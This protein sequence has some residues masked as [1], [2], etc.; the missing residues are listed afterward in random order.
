MELKNGLT[1]GVRRNTKGQEQF[2]ELLW[3]RETQGNKTIEHKPKSGEHWRIFHQSYE[4][5]QSEQ[6]KGLPL[7]SKHKIDTQA[8]VEVK[9]NK[10]IAVKAGEE[11]G[12]MGEYNQTGESGEKLLHLEVFT[13]DN[14]EQFKAKAEAA[15]KQDRE[16]KGIKANFLYVARGSQLYSIANDEAVALE[17][18]KVEI[19]VPLADVAKKT[20]KKKTDKTGKDYYNVQ[21]YLYSLP[22]KNKDGGIYVDSSHLTH[23]LLFPGVNI[24]NQSGNGLCIFKHPLHQNIDP[25]SDLTTEQKNELD[26]MFKSITVEEFKSIVTELR[27][28]VLKHTNLWIPAISSGASPS[29][30]TYEAT[31]KELNRVMN[32]YEINTCLRKIHFL[33]QA[34]HE[35]HYF[36]SMQEYTSP[37][38]SKYDPYRGRGL[39]HLTH[40]KNYEKFSADMGDSNIV[41]NPSIVATNI[42]Y[43]FES[44]GWFWKKGATLSNNKPGV[45]R[46]P[47][48]APKSIHERIKMEG[49][50]CNKSIVSYG[51]LQGTFGVLDL[52]VL[53]DNDWGNTIS[54]LI[55]GGANGFDD[56]IKYR[57]LLKEIMKYELC[58]N[59]K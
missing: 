9:L 45:W 16:K 35:T 8:D 40:K 20:V 22:Q 55:N 11:L 49:A 47:N 15:Y 6:I 59:K 41:N 31:V 7:L 44:G 42:A 24:F 21:P 50:N 14:I 17:K 34:Y 2:D 18:S 26:P 37:Y 28:G 3:Y 25:K 30:K 4:E 58:K 51:N 33:A 29:D 12:L 56:R 13:Y 39:I 53:A 10:A 5:M 52:N 54:W 48:S 23:G 38:T 32:K 43:A 36:Q 19:M 57:N 46:Y 27:K 1:I